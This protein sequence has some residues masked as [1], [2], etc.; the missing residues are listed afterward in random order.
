MRS[1]SGIMLALPLIGQAIAIKTSDDVQK[2]M[3]DDG[4]EM[5]HYPSWQESAVL[6][7]RLLAKANV[8]TFSTVYPAHP[9][10][11]ATKDLG[12]MPVGL[13]EYYADCASV[14]DDLVDVLGEGNP[15][16][17]GLNIG[18]TFKN[19][20]EGS[21]LTITI[22]WW[23]NNHVDQEGLRSDPQAFIRAVDQ[24][25]IDT[26]GMLDHAQANMP[27]MSLIG[28]LENLPKLDD[29][30]REKVENCF[31]DSH[32]D[33]VMWL[34]GHDDAAHRGFWARLVVQRIL[35]VGGFGDR[36]R[37]GWLDAH[38][39]RNVQKADWEAVRLPGEN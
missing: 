16:V 4:M 20:K 30:V 37:I 21:N 8:A 28:Y 27:R 12:G 14:D 24:G 10:G 3:H 36:A 6:A 18:T 32:P 34:P 29:D 9:K 11:R 15:L 39:W 13:P 5:Q 25:E 33:A 26:E 17:L 38:T 22:D 23:S 1:L 31:V 2:A 7:R 19:V 35:W